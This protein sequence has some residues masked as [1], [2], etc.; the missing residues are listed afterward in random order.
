MKKGYIFG[1]IAI[2]GLGLGF[3]ISYFLFPSIPKEPVLPE[4]EPE[5]V[6]EPVPNNPYERVRGKEKPLI[7]V[8]TDP[9][10]DIDDTLA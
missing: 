6:P 5:A 1:L 8:G 7:P 2:L 3:A 9:S 10:L 4:V